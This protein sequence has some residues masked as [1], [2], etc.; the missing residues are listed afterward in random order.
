[1]IINEVP[2]SVWKAFL[3]LQQSSKWEIYRHHSHGRA[4][5]M[6]RTVAFNRTPRFTVQ[7]RVVCDLSIS[8]ERKL[9]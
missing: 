4:Q 9:R 8:S 1:M 7:N 3:L 6:V 5:A 2:I